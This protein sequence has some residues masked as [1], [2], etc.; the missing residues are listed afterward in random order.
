LGLN[1][2]ACA[3]QFFPLLVCQTQPEEHTS[4]LGVSSVCMNIFRRNMV[5]GS[6][7]GRLK[8]GLDE[9][10]PKC[11]GLEVR[12]TVNLQVGL[13]GATRPHGARTRAAAREADLDD[14]VA[15]V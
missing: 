1:L 4:A 14:M 15:V 3:C 11:M 6:S 13:D 10:E 9:F 8:V 7:R 5:I 2:S 12:R